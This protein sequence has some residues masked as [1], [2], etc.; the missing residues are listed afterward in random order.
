MKR[1]WSLITMCLGAVALLVSPVLIVTS[2]SSGPV[3]DPFDVS[4]EAVV[5]ARVS[6]SSFNDFP[7]FLSIRRS[8]V[9]TGLY[10]GTG[11][12][13][14]VAIEPGT[15]LSQG[16]TILFVDGTAVTAV[17]WPFPLYRSLAIG[18]RGYDVAAVQT[19]L[20]DMGL[21]TGEIDGEYT[22]ET[23]RA[24]RSFEQQIGISDTTGVF[25]PEWTIWLPNSSVFVAEILTSVG[26]RLDVGS[27]VYSEPEAAPLAEVLDQERNSL[28][29]DV[30]LDVLVDQVV[31]GIARM[32]GSTVE[33]TVDDYYLETLTNAEPESQGNNPTILPVV[34]RGRTAVELESIPS[35]A[36]IPS[37]DDRF[38]VWISVNSGVYQRTEVDVVDG[39]LGYTLVRPI[40]TAGDILANPLSTLDEPTC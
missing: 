15:E 29:A 6:T 36:V 2:M 19:L 9:R 11:T 40:E 12:V 14:G 5:V 13:T 24:V 27:E 28:V 3:A 38:C 20:S 22:S 30:D 31:I 32:D 26:D 8:E 37:L 7:G 35:S 1:Q 4:A 39:S 10:A 21:F 34:I 17:Q 33:L 25:L 18:N 23:A 16:D